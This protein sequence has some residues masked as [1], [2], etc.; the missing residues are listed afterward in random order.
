MTK[1]EARKAIRWFQ[2]HVGITDWKIKLDFQDSPPGWVR[3]DDAIAAARRNARSKTG[4]IWVSPTRAQENGDSLL[5]NLFHE[6]LHIVEEDVGLPSPT[7]DPVDY[8]WDQLAEICETAYL[9]E[10]KGKR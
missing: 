10:T 8:L 5:L 2:R 1:S 3:Q 7:A 4:T 9:A 6:C